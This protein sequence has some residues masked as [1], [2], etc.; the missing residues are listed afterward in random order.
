M[1]AEGSEAEGRGP[2]TLE[3]YSGEEADDQDQPGSG[4]YATLHTEGPQVSAGSSDH[5][6]NCMPC[7]F[8]CFTRRGCNRGSECRF[9]HMTHQSKL[10]QR[11]EAWKK[12]Q[13]EKRKTIRERVAQE[14]QSRRPVTSPSHPALCD[15]RQPGGKGEGG[16]GRG[17]DLMVAKPQNPYDLPISDKR[18]SYRG[19]SGDGKAPAPLAASMVPTGVNGVGGGAAAAD[20]AHGGVV[21]SVFAYNPPRV[22]CTIGQEV[23]LLPQLVAVPVQFRLGGPLPGGLVLDQVSGV[24]RGCPTAASPQKSFVIEADLLGGRTV[25]AAV[26]IEVVD[27]TRG[28]FVIGHMSEYEPGKFMLLLYVPD[29]NG[30]GGATDEQGYS[31]QGTYEQAFG[32]GAKTYVGGGD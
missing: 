29:E 32:G 12:Q 7:T 25:R 2:E 30:S 11:R 15:T 31:A 19:G 17:A 24:I 21:T 26:E 28:G 16:L 8:Y 9:C 23:E 10:Q 1:S 6:D 3:D 20:V 18:S 14:A 27:F 13:R 22:V 5:P 4:P